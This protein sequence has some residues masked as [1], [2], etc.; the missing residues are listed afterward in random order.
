MK[1]T[2]SNPHLNVNNGTGPACGQNGVPRSIVHQDYHAFGPRL[3]FAYDLLGDG[4]TVLRGGYGIFYFLDYGGINNQL[5]EQ[6]P[7][8]GSNDYSGHQRLLHYVHRPTLVSNTKPADGGYNC[9]GYTSPSTVVTALPARGYPRLQSSASAGRHQHDCREPGQQQ[10]HGAGVEPASG[11]ADWFQE[12]T[13]CRLRRNRGTNLSS[14]YP[15]NLY[16]F[17]TGIQNFPGLG[18]ST[19]TTITAFQTTTDCRY[20]QNTVPTKG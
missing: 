2:T 1:R 16:Q 7:F 15:Y 14:Y 20:M 11:E 19:T 5:G 3:G 10:Q 4:K 6:A 17:G 18:A 9:T 13:E 12:C 8:G